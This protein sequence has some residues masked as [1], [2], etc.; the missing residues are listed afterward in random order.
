MNESA[1]IKE[2]HARL[3]VENAEKPVPGDGEVLVKVEVIAFSPIESKI[4]RYATHPVPYPLVLGGSFAGTVEAVGPDVTALQPGDLVAVNRAGK[5]Q[6]DSRFGGFQKYAL[7]CVSSSS[8][9]VPGTP[10][11]AAAASILNLA[12][13]A[14]ALSIHLGLARPSLSSDNPAAEAKGK[15]VLVYGGSSPTGG[16]AIN[17]AVIAGYTVITTSSPQNRGFV[18][19]LGPV[20]VIDHTLPADQIAD[21]IRAHGPYDAILDTIGLPPVTN[22]LVGYL[23]S[24]GG[25]TYNTMT[26]LFGPENPVPDTVQ[27]RFAPYSWSFEQPANLDFA[28]WFYEEYVPQGLASGLI[29][30]TRPQWVHGGLAKAQH[31]LDL[32]DQNAVSGHKLVMNSW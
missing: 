20:A 2:K 8:K 28:R 18:E 16:L 31:A 9:L 12:T 4:Q 25:G 11:E 24:L 1:W 10:L 15:K 17:Y 3:T 22:M 23:S 26:P 30:P 14:S 7:A 19:S 21:Q 13:V 32:L 6:G 27:R 29:V 5:V